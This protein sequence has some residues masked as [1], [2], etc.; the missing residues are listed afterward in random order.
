MLGDIQLTV[1]EGNQN[2]CQYCVSDDVEEVARGEGRHSKGVEVDDGSA[3]LRGFG[4][5][6][7]FD[8]RC[9]G[10]CTYMVGH[11]SGF[12]GWGYR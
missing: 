4:G 3:Y 7:P 9:M 6:L 1:V 5:H 12:Y 2:W 8:N 11:R 10:E